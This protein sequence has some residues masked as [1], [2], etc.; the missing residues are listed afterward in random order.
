MFQ[1]GKGLW[2]TLGKRFGDEWKWTGVKERS[3]CIAL[4][5]LTDC[6]GT[7][8]GQLRGH[9]VGVDSGVELA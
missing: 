4:V 5:R 6:E 2:F 7:R 3:V 9:A 8:V 1:G